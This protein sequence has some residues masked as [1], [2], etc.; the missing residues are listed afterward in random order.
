MSCNLVA[1]ITSLECLDH[2]HQLSSRF[3]EVVRLLLSHNTCILLSGRNHQRSTFL[4]PSNVVLTVVHATSLVGT[5]LVDANQHLAIQAGRTLAVHDVLHAPLSWSSS[6]PQ[7][8][9][10]SSFACCWVCSFLHCWVCLFSFFM[11]CLQ[12]APSSR[13]RP[14][15]SLLRA[16]FSPSADCD[17]DG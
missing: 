3:S 1:A 6:V 8:V 11:S 9:L 2:S 14:E 13:P 16:A 10:C 15:L 4:R 17:A 5:L 7:A 12:A